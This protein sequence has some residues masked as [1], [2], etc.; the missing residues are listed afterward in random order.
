MKILMLENTYGAFMHRVY[1]ARFLMPVKTTDDG[2]L[3]KRDT[4]LASET[5]FSRTIDVPR[6]LTMRSSFG[7]LKAT[8]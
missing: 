3:T 2:N 7:K 8:V 1:G 6:S 4:N 5:F